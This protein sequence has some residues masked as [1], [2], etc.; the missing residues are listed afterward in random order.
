MFVGRFLGGSNGMILMLGF[1]VVSVLVSY[2]F[3][4]SIVLR[5]NGARE[6]REMDAPELYA[7]VRR[8]VDQ[9]G[10]PMPKV[11][12]VETASPNAFATGRSPDHAAIAVTTGILGILTPEELQAVIAHEMGHVRNRDTLIS[13]VVGVMASAISNLA[14]FGFFFGGSRDERDNGSGFGA[15]LAIILGPIAALLLQA[16]ISRSREFSADATGAVITHNPLALASAL[17]KLE[18][19]AQVRPMDVQPAM[20]HLYIVNP[21]SGQS[22]A[23]LFSTHPPTPERVERLEEIAEAMRGRS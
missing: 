17:R 22:L 2:W 8:V 6:V 9:A 14:Y 16:A 20:A 7:T 11:C 19:G 12:I 18:R 4:D 23:N 3:S 5:M 1:S 21:L 15:L 10:L 13:A